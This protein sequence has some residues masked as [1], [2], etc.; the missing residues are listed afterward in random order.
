MP[1]RSSKGRSKGSSKA[2]AKAK[3]PAK[4]KATRVTSKVKRIATPKAGI[5]APG[6]S[7]VVTIGR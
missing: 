7:I 6:G 4:V 1:K 2:R 3:A 5:K